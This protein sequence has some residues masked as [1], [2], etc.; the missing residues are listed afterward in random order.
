MMIKI[1]KRYASKYIYNER[2]KQM[3]T[4]DEIKNAINITENEIETK[5]KKEEYI[6]VYK[7]LLNNIKKM[8]SIIKDKPSNVS[9]L[10][11]LIIYD[12]L[13]YT[14]PEGEYY[15]VMPK[16]CREVQETYIKYIFAMDTR[17]IQYNNSSKEKSIWEKLFG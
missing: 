7:I 5:E 12:G 8:N 10:D 17:K 3:I 2:D 16:I 4:E 9:D 11:Q 13:I 1:L 6:A 14:N 15:K